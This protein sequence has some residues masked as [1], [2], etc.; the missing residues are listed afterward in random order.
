MGHGAWRMGHAAPAEPQRLRT[1]EWGS[2]EAVLT[3]L[4]LPLSDSLGKGAKAPQLSLLSPFGPPGRAVPLPS[5]AP[6]GSPG[7]QSPV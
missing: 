1:G 3:L 7:T 6:T 5:F 2:G 4:R